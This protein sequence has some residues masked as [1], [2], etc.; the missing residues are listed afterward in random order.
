MSLR[1][2]LA[3]CFL[4]LATFA[5][6][7]GCSSSAA[8]KQDRLCTPGAYVF[9]RCADRSE[10]TKLCKEDGRSF[11]PCTTG[12][13]GECSG[14]EIDDP[15]TGNPIDEIDG[16]T[17]PVPQTSE[18]EACP[19]QPVALTPGV[20]TVID[21]DTSAAKDDFQGRP[22]ACAVGAGGAD[23][24]YRLQPKGSGTL[25]VKV[26]ALAPLDATVYLRK[27][28]S[29]EATQTSCAETTP[30]AGLEQ[31]S[32]CIGPTQESFLIIDGASGTK[33]KYQ[34][35]LKLT[36]GACCGDGKVDTNEACDDGNK[37]EGDGCSNDCRKVD[38]N[39]TAADSCP[40][41][42]VHVW[43]GQKPTGTGTTDPPGGLVNKFTNTGTSCGVSASNVNAAPDHLYAATAHAAGTMKVTLTPDAAFNAMLVARKTCSDPQTQLPDTSTCGNLNTAGGVETLSFPVTNG[44]TVTVAAEGALNAKGP[45]TIQFEIQ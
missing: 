23:H 43:P 13:G 35:T 2:V 36:T 38:G 14:G 12:A 7:Q 31:F 30:A 29:D 37:D 32:R 42:E 41:H 33:G 25:S 8:E 39:P 1:T 21:G 11:E 22:G 45:Y 28:C 3:S 16:G 24:V 18:A 6:A 5:T 17:T 27:T 44:E 15:N 26:Q 34:L 10:G 40:G 20:S 19:G 4:S 9:C